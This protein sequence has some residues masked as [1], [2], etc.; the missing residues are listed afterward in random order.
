M[1]S[2]PKNEN[3]G[4]NKRKL[5][6]QPD[7]VLDK[8]NRELLELCRGAQNLNGLAA[9]TVIS[10][11][12][13]NRRLRKLVDAGFIVHEN[14][15]YRTTDA[16]R[17]RLDRAVNPVVAQARK[18]A[19]IWPFLKLL[20]SVHRALII[21]IL[22]ALIA[23]KSQH[24]H[25]RHPGFVLLG[26]TMRLKSHLMKVL[27]AALG[28]YVEKCHIQIME[29]RG[30]GLIIRL[31]GKG[32]KVYE[33]EHLSQPLCWLD[34]VSLADKSVKKDIIAKI[35][36]IDESILVFQLEG[37]DFSQPFAF[38]AKSFG[39]VVGVRVNHEAHGTGETE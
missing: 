1:M 20:P 28:L 27:C 36:G 4:N 39:F 31:D 6:K 5:G 34:E 18:L 22:G 14:A 13:V 3:K 12:T 30:R 33:S 8:Q 29:Q 7:G 21:L 37:Y 15:M 19:D 38:H 26:P 23:R 25:D 32:E 11:A 2:K 9:V 17:T 10:R 16:G 35:F 24:N